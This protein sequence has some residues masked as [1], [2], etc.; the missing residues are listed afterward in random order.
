MLLCTTGDRCC[1]NRSGAPS[2]LGRSGS[3]ASSSGNTNIGRS[4]SADS[5]IGNVPPRSR[6]NS[7]GSKNGSNSDFEDFLAE[8]EKPIAIRGGQAANRPTIQRS[9]TEGV[10]VDMA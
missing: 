5:A 10:D 9:Q 8:R 7:F 2:L 1:T 4:P 3:T 6:K